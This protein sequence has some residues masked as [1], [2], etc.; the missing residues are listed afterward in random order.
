MNPEKMD[1][2]LNIDGLPKLNQAGIKTL[3]NPITDNEFE[4]TVK[5]CQESVEE[6]TDRFY[7]I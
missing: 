5:S 3:N 4:V 2:V 6:F 7:N 1:R